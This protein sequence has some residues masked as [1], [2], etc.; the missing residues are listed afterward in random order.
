MTQT[1]KFLFICEDRDL[2]YIVEEDSYLA[3][4]ITDR[5]DWQEVT[6]LDSKEEVLEG[7]KDEG[8]W[9]LCD[10][11]RK[12]YKMARLTQGQVDTF[13]STESLTL[14]GREWLNILQSEFF[15]VLEIEDDVI[16]FGAE[17]HFDVVGD[18]QADYDPRKL[19]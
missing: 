2:A 3:D 10:D 18:E 19:V 15:S 8:M 1:S 16:E 11:V 12:T 5:E 13:Y 7:L 17:H 14:F 4:T 9:V 6:F